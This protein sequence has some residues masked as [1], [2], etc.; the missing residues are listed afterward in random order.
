MCC[1][2]T[3]QVTRLTSF[4][5]VDVL[6]VHPEKLALLVE[7]P[8]KVMGHVGLVVSWIQL[9]GQGK[10]GIRVM[11][12]KADLKY[13]LS[14]GEVILLQVVV[15]TAAWRPVRDTCQPREV[16]WYSTHLS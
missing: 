11:V 16:T 4:Q 3:A 7:Q 8:D 12:E 1:L 13:G 14:V 6:R 5:A 9:F 2:F 10:E 15:E